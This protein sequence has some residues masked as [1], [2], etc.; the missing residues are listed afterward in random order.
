MKPTKVMRYMKRQLMMMAATVLLTACSQTEESLTD[1][2]STTGDSPQEVAFR[3]YTQRGTTTR[4]GQPGELTTEALKNGTHKDAGIGLF[5]Y[6]TSI[7][8]YNSY[9]HKPNYMYNQQVTWDGGVNRWT[10]SPMKYWPNGTDNDGIQFQQEHLSFF[11]YAPWVEVD[12]QTGT[13]TDGSSEGITAVSR[14]HAIGDPCVYFSIPKTLD[15]QVD[16]CWGT[17]DGGYT[18]DSGNSVV[19]PGDGLPVIDLTKMESRAGTVDMKFHHALARLNVTIDAMVDNVPEREVDGSTRIYL[20]SISFKGF[21]MNGLLNLHNTAAAAP[22]WYAQDGHNALPTESVIFHDGRRDGSEGFDS[23]A[24]G[25]EAN[26]M[27]NP[28]LVQIDASTQPGIT[29]TAVNLF[30]SDDAEAPLY[31][32]PNGGQMDI[33]IAYDIETRDD[34]LQGHVL[35]DGKTLG[36]SSENRVSI[37]SL[38]PSIEAGKAYTLRLHVGISGVRTEVSVSDWI[39][40]T[41]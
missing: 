22:R 14:L 4:A 31:I 13:V 9:V 12:A 20:R 15:K 6:Y 28:S 17:A 25:G 8:R 10:Y 30:N 24:N 33:T 36:Y 1:R 2:G 40:K 11:A 37:S 34:K 39:S 41:M 19:T 5:G 35:S 29:A 16:L 32:I 38:F 27:L 23:G 3:F 7:E 18:D 21:C 26:Q